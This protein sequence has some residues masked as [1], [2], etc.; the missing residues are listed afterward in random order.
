MAV[1]WGRIHDV[2]P[3]QMRRKGLIEKTST[4]IIFINPKFQFTRAGN[5][6]TCPHHL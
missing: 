3:I 1:F 6:V 2:Y 5:L 4:G